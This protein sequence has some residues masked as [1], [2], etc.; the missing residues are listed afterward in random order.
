MVK[1]FLTRNNVD[2]TKFKPFDKKKPV[3]RKRLLKLRNS[4][5][6]AT[7][8][9]CNGKL[10]LELLE[11]IDNKE[12]LIGEVIVPR[13]FE[14]FIINQDGKLEVDVI[15]ISGRK[16]D[17]FDVRQRILDDQ[18]ELGLL[19]SRDETEYMDLSEVEIMSRYLFVLV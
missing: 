19:R 5:V 2:I 14:K 10:R 3:V 18:E 16:L 11:R 17:L 9:R 1:E 4:K 12:I 8:P 6:S 15:T 13:D 7:T